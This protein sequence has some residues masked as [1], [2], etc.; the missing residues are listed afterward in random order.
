[1]RSGKCIDID[2][3]PGFNNGAN[4]QLWTCEDASSSSSTDQK[5]ELIEADD[6]IPTDTQHC[7]QPSDWTCDWPCTKCWRSDGFDCDSDGD[8]PTGFQCGNANCDWSSGWII[9][10]RDDCCLPPPPLECGCNANGCWPH[11][12][13]DCD[14]DSDCLSNPD[15][16]KLGAT[17]CGNANCPWTS[18]VLQDQDDCCIIT[19]CTGE[20]FDHPS[21]TLWVDQAPDA[22]NVVADLDFADVKVTRLALLS[23]PTDSFGDFLGLNNEDEVFLKAECDGSLSVE[24]RQHDFKQCDQHTNILHIRCLVSDSMGD[25]KLTVREDDTSNDEENMQVLDA[26]MLLPLPL[27]ST[28][29]VRF[30]LDNEQNIFDSALLFTAGMGLF[31]LCISD[32]VV[33]CSAV[34]HL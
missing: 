28:V 31:E 3:L 23:A 5:W 30:Y 27:G 21:E 6:C 33:Q 19:A 22:V 16:A 25:L 13:F 15:M 9:E 20:N 7:G 32:L 2:G 14:S 12:G 10:T 26:S 1:M 24:S 29:R 8:C 11:V 34:G 17:K 4:A 18:G